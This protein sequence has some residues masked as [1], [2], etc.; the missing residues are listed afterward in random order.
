MLAEA[1][2]SPEELEA[3]QQTHFEELV[4]AAKAKKSRRANSCNQGNHQ[5]LLRVSE[6]NKLRKPK[7]KNKTTDKTAAGLLQLVVRS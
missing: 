3:V 5:D 2:I 1:K 4:A 7:G 6:K